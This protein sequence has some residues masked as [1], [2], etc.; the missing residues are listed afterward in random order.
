MRETTAEGRRGGGRLYGLA[1]PYVR[2]GE[3]GRER[4]RGGLTGKE[5]L[6]NDGSGGGLDDVVW[7]QQTCISVMSLRAGFSEKI[8]PVGVGATL[9]LL[10]IP[11]HRGLNIRI[12]ESARP[13][14]IESTYREQQ[15]R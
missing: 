12:R 13:E 5:E 1:Y 11:C 2:A 10:L 7:L 8:S 9:T 15:P 6:G 4:R 3:H 14:G